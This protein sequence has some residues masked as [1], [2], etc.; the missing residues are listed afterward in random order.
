MGLSTIKPTPAVGREAAPASGQQLH[1]GG[2]RARS[3]FDEIGHGDRLTEEA[4]RAVPVIKV[5]EFVRTC[6]CGTWPE[7]L[8][9]RRGSRAARSRPTGRER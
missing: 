5:S 7:P 6:R 2:M 3:D 9:G 4:A 1:G 8:A